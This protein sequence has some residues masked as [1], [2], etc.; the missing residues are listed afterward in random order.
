MGSGASKGLQAAVDSVSKDELAQALSSLA[1]GDRAKLL[2]AIGAASATESTPAPP[3]GPPKTLTIK[4]STGAEM[5]AIA[6]GCAFYDWKGMVAHGK[7]EASVQVPVALE[8]GYR[9]LDTARSWGTEG[10]VGAALKAHIAAGVLKREDLFITA[11]VCHPMQSWVEGYEVDETLRFD[12]DDASLDV[13]KKVAED[14]RESLANLGVDYVDMLLMHWPGNYC[15]HT[16][17]AKDASRNRSMRQEIYE[18]FES[19]HRDGLAK[20]IG[21]CN[22]SKQHLQDLLA[23]A[24]IKPTVAHLEGTPYGLDDEMVAFC[25][26]NDV[27]VMAHQVFGT[28]SMGLFEDP[29]LSEVASKYDRSV[30]QVILRWLFQRGLGAIPRSSSRDH[31]TSNLDLDFT[32]ESE[33]VERINSLNRNQHQRPDPNTIA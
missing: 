28:G 11:K 15:P 30:A 25:L 19:F 6:F 23:D 32:I 33:D 26:A 8:S 12:F 21:V 24:S 22:F 31:M 14:V 4:L 2:A 13:K 20:G 3:P 16:G 18:V 7:D 1:E 27:A 29:V 17:P 10:A 9:H 5:P